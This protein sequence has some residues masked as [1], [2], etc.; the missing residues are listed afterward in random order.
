[1]QQQNSFKRRIQFL[2]CLAGLWF[3][4]VGFLILQQWPDLPK[5][6]LG[7]FLL[8][9]LGPPI[10]LLGEG[11]FGWL[12]SKERGERISNKRFSLLRIAFALSIVLLIFIVATVASFLLRQ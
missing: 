3:F 11:F 2:F 5:T 4:L 9:L 7:W 12:F 6:K 1:M 10:Y 8:V